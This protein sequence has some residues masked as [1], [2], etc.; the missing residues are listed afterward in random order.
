MKKDSSKLLLL[1]VNVLLAIA[2]PNHQFHSAALAR[3]G[4]ATGN[5]ATCALTE[6]GFIRLSSNPAVVGSVKSPSDAVFLLAEM[7]ADPVH[8][9]LD[10]L[11]SPA[12]GE[13]RRGFEKIL[14]FKQVTDA[15]LL[16]LAR[17][18]NAI[19]VTFDARLKELSGSDVEVLKG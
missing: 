2:W 5:W 17:R 14:G 19:F 11:P 10:S 18:H 9:R 12:D 7:T 16:L 4:A 15:Y 6:I 1:D 13:F 8:V 3:M